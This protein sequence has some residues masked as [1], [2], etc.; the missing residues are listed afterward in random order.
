VPTH[1]WE[2]VIKEEPYFDVNITKPC[3]GTLPCMAMKRKDGVRSLHPTHSVV[4]FGIR[5]NE[6]IIGEETSATPAPIGGCWNRLYDE[7]AK[8]LL[9]GVGHEKNTY[10]HAVDEML[11]IPNRLSDDT[12]TITIKDSNE[13]M[14]TT[15]PFRRHFTT[16]ISCC[17]SEYYPNYKKP[18]EEL[19]A[20]TYSMLGNALVYCCDAVK[21]TDIISKLWERTDHDLCINEEEIP[22]SYYRD[23]K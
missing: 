16:G 8:I 14:Y 5:A 13:K 19:G 7:H 11:D 4:A 9:I 12:F 23:L 3:I 6:Y 20:V 1:T 15:P 2:N 10:F 17:C 21:C 22:V 18:L